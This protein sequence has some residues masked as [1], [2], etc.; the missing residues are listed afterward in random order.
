MAK[1]KKRKIERRR[2]KRKNLELLVQN[3]FESF[4][5]FMQEHSSNISA[6]GMFVRTNNPKEVG[7][8]VYLRFTLKDGLP[9]I[10]GIAKVVRVNRL[11]EKD[12]IPGMGL[13]F[14]ALEEDSR[15]LIDAIVQENIIKDED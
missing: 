8:T 9:L 1:K 11:G 10:E 14:V 7:S 3:R 12:K 5:S 15:E 4:D 2:Y 6:G 13:E